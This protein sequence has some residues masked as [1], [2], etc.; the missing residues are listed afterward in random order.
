M[1]EKLGALLVRRNKPEAAVKTLTRLLE[2]NPNSSA[3][4][5][6][7]GDA[8][9]SLKRNKESMEAYESALKIEHQLDV[10]IKLVKAIMKQGQW[11][12]ALDRLTKAKNPKSS[13]DAEFI[14][15]IAACQ[16]QLKNFSAAARNY[17]NAY[18]LELNP[19][20]SCQGIALQAS[21][22]YTLAIETLDAMKKHEGKLPQ[23]HF[24]RPTLHH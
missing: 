9:A 7:L 21:G 10:L 15:L 22:N 18:D 8:F 24:Q 17:Q 20:P 3:G 4:W 1:T 2:I 12:L 5:I 16:Y 11:K 13:K 14:R 23:V 19:E 6:Y